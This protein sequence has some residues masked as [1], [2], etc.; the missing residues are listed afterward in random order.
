MKKLFKFQKLKLTLCAVL[1]FMLCAFTLGGV[2]S[3]KKVSAEEITIND[4]EVILYDFPGLPDEAYSNDNWQLAEMNDTFTGKYYAYTAEDLISFNLSS[5]QFIQNQVGLHYSTGSFQF[6]IPTEIAT[7]TINGNE[8]SYYVFYIPE[9]FDNTYIHE[10]TMFGQER[11]YWDNTEVF[12]SAMSYEDDSK[13]DVYTYVPGETVEPEEPETPD[14][15]EVEVINIYDTMFFLPDQYDKSNWIESDITATSAYKD[16]YGG[17][18]FRWKKPS[19]SEDTHAFNLQIKTNDTLKTEGLSF[20]LD[21]EKITFG[22]YSVEYQLKSYDG[23]LYLEFYLPEIYDKTVCYANNLTTTYHDY[24]D[25][26]FL[27]SYKN[28]K[29]DIVFITAPEEPEEP[30]QGGVSGG[31]WD[32]FDGE[33]KEDLNFVESVGE[34]VSSW[35]GVEDANYNVWGWVTLVLGGLIVVGFIGLIF[36][37]K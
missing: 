27:I 22:R 1:G 36:K 15:P 16:S 3:F 10:D 24:F 9:K 32:K 11:I 19:T 17:K 5:F 35:F 25:N 8:G 23:E 6:Y 4:L 30:E 20:N 28:S 12:T 18:W 34:T 21:T 13:I 14:E 2:N 26:T 33:D 7:L 29:A 31:I 37:L